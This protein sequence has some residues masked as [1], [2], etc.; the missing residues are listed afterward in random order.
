MDKKNIFIGVLLLVSAFGMIMWNEAREQ[1]AQAARMR[2]AQLDAQAQTEAERLGSEL[3]QA[4]IRPGES[5]SV[6]PPA[7]DTPEAF[8]QRQT[9]DGVLELDTDTDQDEARSER[10]PA[11]LI[12]IENAFIRVHFNARGGAVE[13][14]ELLEYREDLNDPSPFVLNRNAPQPALAIGRETRAGFTP[15]APRYTVA[16]QSGLEIAFTAQLANGLMIE[17]RYALTA[18]EDGPAPYTIRHSTR[19][20]N[21]T[22]T[23]Y[24]L[25]RLHLVVGAAMPTEADPWGFNLNASYSEEGKFRAIPASRF[26]PGGIPLFRTAAREQVEHR[27]SITWA[28]VKNQFFT[29]LVTPDL[30]AEAIL[31]RKVEYEPFS[32]TPNEPSVGIIASIEF[33]IPTIEP[34]AVSELAADFYA[35]PKSFS[36]LSRMEKGQEDVMQ[37]GWF[38]GLYLGVISF[39]AKILLTLMNGIQAVVGNWG[40]TII[41][42]TLIIRLCMWPLTA[43]AARTSKRMQKLQQPIKDLREKYKDDQRKLNEEMLKLWK[44]HKI[45]PLAGCLP[46]LVQMPIFISFFNMLRSSSDLRFAEFLF[47]QDLSMPDRLITFGDASLP[48]IGNSLNVLP[49]VWLISMYFQ[50]KLMPQPSVDNAQVKIFRFMPF[51]FFPFTYIFSSGLVLYW[52]TSNCFSIFQ[53]IMTNRQRDEEDVAID[54]ELLERQEKKSAPTGPL[55]KKK[56]KKRPGDDLRSVRRK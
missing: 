28:A 9:E 36:R 35:G 55:I 31:A 29:T 10:D 13:S 19:F 24:T 54:E 50:M 52:T 11:P 44:K 4:E 15:F 25:D 34:G 43:R 41:L 40:I 45:N 26:R 20:I 14:I 1:E 12:T 49:F 46:V 38:L 18:D 56:K 48:I 32:R 17:R 51:I 5:G 30:P 8:F 16:E 21:N 37:L 39:L 6:R 3:S 2:Q 7:I 33:L 27:G 23:A 42:A 53:Q 47:I 22:E